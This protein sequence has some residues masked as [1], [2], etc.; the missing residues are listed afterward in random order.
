MKKVLIVSKILCKYVTSEMYF[1]FFPA[2]LSHLRLRRAASYRSFS[3]GRSLRTFSSFYYFTHYVGCNQSFYLSLLIN[4]ERKPMKY[5]FT[6]R[7][8]RDNMGSSKWN[9]MYKLNPN[10]SEGVIPLSVAD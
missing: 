1:A 3:S 7:V 2:L 9:Q 10:V 4:K 8:N 5:D 6:T